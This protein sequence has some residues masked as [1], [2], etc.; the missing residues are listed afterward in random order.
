MYTTKADFL[1]QESTN[2][3][4]RLYDSLESTKV[5]YNRYLTIM[6]FSLRIDQQFI[7]TIIVLFPLLIA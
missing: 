3:L 4:L 6:L 2:V 7:A 5:H 1:T